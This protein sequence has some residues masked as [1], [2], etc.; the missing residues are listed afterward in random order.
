[1]MF[2][3]GLPM[4]IDMSHI[5]FSIAAFQRQLNRAEKWN[6]NKKPI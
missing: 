5:T 4:V 1:M 2:P 6:G 3:S